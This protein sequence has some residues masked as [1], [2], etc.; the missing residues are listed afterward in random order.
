[1]TGVIEGDTVHA[2][3][4]RTFVTDDGVC[5]VID[6]K[7]SEPGEG[8]PLAEFLQ[9]EAESYRPQLQ[10]YLELL[11]RRSADVARLRGALYF[12]MIDAWC[13]ME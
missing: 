6:F 10:V 7:T 4:D 8:E 9:R 11:R 1:L 13:E 3:I 12:P 2:V 5:W